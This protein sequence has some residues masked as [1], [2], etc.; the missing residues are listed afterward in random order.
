VRVTRRIIALGVA[1]GMVP[2]IVMR[3]A[4]TRAWPRIRGTLRCEGLYAPV[5]VLRDRW[6]VAHIYAANAHDLFFAQ[7][8]VHAQDRFW[9]MELERRLGEGR[10][11]ELFGRPALA[12]DRLMRTLG[13]HHVAAREVDLLDKD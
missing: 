13:A 2:W 11:A 7:G 10:L 8:F 4:L 3:R 1:I 12:Q 5:T 6:G 9:Q